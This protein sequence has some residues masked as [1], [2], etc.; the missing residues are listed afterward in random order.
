MKRFLLVIT[1]LICLTSFIIGLLGCGS[2]S[3][4]IT[5]TPTSTSTPTSTPTPSPSP[6][7][8]SFTKLAYAV[9]YDNNHIETNGAFALSLN[10]LNGDLTKL[11]DNSLVSFQSGCGY[12]SI[13]AD[14]A[15][16]YLYVSN[17]DSNS[18]SVYSI[19]DNGSLTHICSP[20]TGST[21][22]EVVVDPTGKFVYTVIDGG[23]G[24]GSIS[25]FVVNS[26]NGQ[27]TPV[28]DSPF[29]AGSAPISAAVDTAGQYLYVANANANT[30][31]TYS[32]N[33]TSGALTQF[34]VFSTP[35]GYSNN[36]L[37]VEPQW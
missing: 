29:P 31:T 30:I 32:I 17:K 25:A 18:L 19:N 26:V 13:V 7:P 24:S 8:T 1:L 28:N 4:Q 34:D 21:P 37:S 9:H 35:S 16:K 5:A 36:S 27:L 22:T 15:G 10:T 33:P 14:P 11:N 6:T 20:A 23:S 3:N 12:N 2:R